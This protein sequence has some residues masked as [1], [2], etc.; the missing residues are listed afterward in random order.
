MKPPLRSE[1]DR[2]AMVEGVASGVIDVIVSSHEPQGADT[3]R[4]P[5]ATAAAGTVGLETLLPAA[6]S[7]YHDG[8]C[9]RCH[10][11][12]SRYRAP[13]RFWALNAAP[14]PRARPPT[15]CCWTKA[16]PSWWTREKLH[17]RARNTAFEGRKFQGRAEKT[18]VGGECVFRRARFRKSRWISAE[19]SHRRG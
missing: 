11:L 15:W 8:R 13:A 10:V 4:Q 17:S 9:Q 18:F 16:S 7:L 3:K 6:L 1:A 12:E 5:F 14:W 19:T 2:A